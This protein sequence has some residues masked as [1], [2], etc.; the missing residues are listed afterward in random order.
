MDI[1]ELSRSIR[2]KHQMKVPGL[3]VFIAPKGVCQTL[4][5]ARLFKVSEF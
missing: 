4:S 2:P 5:T 3:G 1:K